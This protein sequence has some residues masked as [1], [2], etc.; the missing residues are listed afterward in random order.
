MVN[1]A[2]AAEVE[3]IDSPTFQLQDLTALRREAILA[4][5]LGFSGKIALHPRQV[6]IINQVFSPDAE[7]LEAARRVVA[8]GHRSGQGITTVDGVM[9]GRPFFEASQRLLDEFDPSG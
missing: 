5:D 6:A 4:Q 3:A 7:S 9:V 2:R 8:A 1:A